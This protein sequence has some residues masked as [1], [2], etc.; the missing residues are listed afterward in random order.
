MA[1]VQRMT[2]TATNLATLSIF[3]TRGEEKSESN[4]I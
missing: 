4:K 3:Y 1:A 2:V